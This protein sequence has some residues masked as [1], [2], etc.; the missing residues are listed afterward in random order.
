VP[1]LPDVP[2]L[3]EGA[4]PGFNSISWIGLLAPAG[5]PKEVIEKISADVRT[6]LMADDVKQKLI[7]L[8]AVPAGSTPAQ[9]Q[10]LID[11]DRKRY[12]AIIKEKN[13]SAD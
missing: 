3:A 12:A 9:F 6:V 1:A 2:T 4:V 7:E 13:I 11:K 5:T 10:A 8:G